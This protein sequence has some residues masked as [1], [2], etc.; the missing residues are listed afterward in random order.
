M[1][2]A[3]YTDVAARVG[4]TLSASSA[5]TQSQVT[6]FI[7]QAE[8]DLNGELEAADLTVP[9]T[10]ADGISYLAAYVCA[11]AAMFWLQNK[12]SVTDESDATQQIAAFKA[13]WDQLINDIRS[14]PSIVAVK[15]GQGF[16]GAAGT[17]ALRSYHTDNTDGLSI[18]AGDFDPVFTRQKRKNTDS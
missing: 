13:E 6:T 3:L 2:Y 15:I 8:A 4:R 14:N 16:A 11:R 7:A 18:S 17:S 9:V 5:P 1:A 10:D 12:D